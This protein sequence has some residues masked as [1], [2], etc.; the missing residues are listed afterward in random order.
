VDEQLA[1][2]PA[3]EQ[4][5]TEPEQQAAQ[6]PIGESFGEPAAAARDNDNPLLLL[7]AAAAALAL[8]AVG[9][10]VLLRRRAVAGAPPRRPR[11][12]HSRSR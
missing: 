4:P 10:S 6:Q 1:P 12:S 5:N 9:V 7:G 2:G 3:A 8:V 11:G